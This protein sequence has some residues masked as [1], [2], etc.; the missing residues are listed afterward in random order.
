MTPPE[1][2]VGEYAAVSVVDDGVGMTADTLAKA[3]EPFFTTKGVG[4]GSGLGLSMVQGF[5]AQSGGTVRL[6]SAVGAGT[7]AEIW[8]PRAE[9]N[10]PEITAPLPS[11]LPAATARILLCD[12]DGDARAAI[13]AI[14]RAEGHAVREAANGPEALEIL[15]GGQEVDI[16]VTDYA[17]PGMNGAELSAEVT[18]RRQTVRTLLISGHPAAFRDEERTLPVLAKPFTPATLAARIAEIQGGAG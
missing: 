6:I 1:L 14:L 2:P 13:A 4:M 18:K 8:L 9:A 10:L 15:D 16:L 11:L 12:D 17:M 5:A 3:S 7:R